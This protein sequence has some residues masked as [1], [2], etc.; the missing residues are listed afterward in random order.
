MENQSIARQIFTPGI[1]RDLQ[2]SQSS[3]LGFVFKI[4]LGIVVFLLIRY[5]LFPNIGEFFKWK[6]NVADT[7]FVNGDGSVDVNAKRAQYESV[8]QQLNLALKTSYSTAMTASPRCKAFER[9]MRELNLNE[10]RHCANIF[11]NSYRKTVRE[12]VNETNWT[13]CGYMGI[14]YGEK[15]KERLNVLGIP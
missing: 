13:G 12:M 8:A 1:N 14:D 2:I 9:W 6:V 4:I 15:F 3:I 11:K 7:D 10:F 5:W